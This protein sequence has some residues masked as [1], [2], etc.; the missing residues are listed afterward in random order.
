MAK[1]EIKS[2]EFRPKFKLT[3][4]NAKRLKNIAKIMEM[5]IS[6]YIEFIVLRN[7]GGTL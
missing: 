1:I 2:E 6:E 3:P 5:S 4:S 7:I